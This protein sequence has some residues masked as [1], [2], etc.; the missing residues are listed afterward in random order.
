MLLKLLME[1]N[2][3]CLL[4]IE[5]SWYCSKFDARNEL[6][7]IL[8]CACMNKQIQ[9][10][11]RQMGWTNMILCYQKVGKL[12]TRKVSFYTCFMKSL[13]SKS[14]GNECVRCSECSRG[15][16]CP[17]WAGRDTS[18][19]QR[20]STKNITTSDLHV[21]LYSAVSSLTQRNPV[22]CAGNS[23]IPGSSSCSWATLSNILSSGCWKGSACSGKQQHNPNIY[24]QCLT[25]TLSRSPEWRGDKHTARKGF[26]LGDSSQ[27]STVS[28]LRD[29]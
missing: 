17:A 6:T 2:W 11:Y 15:C 5:A 3:Y 20:L 8:T 24:L 13:Y 14:C 16:T 1:G 4:L 19:G 28:E 23:L 7:Y 26:E 10:R 21:S 27:S 22:C 18:H 25:W 9:C 29:W 12:L